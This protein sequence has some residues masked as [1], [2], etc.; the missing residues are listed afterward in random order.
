MN[1]D[2]A[3][4]RTIT[5]ALASVSNGDHPFGAVVL[6]GGAVVAD[7][8]NEVV[9]TVDPTAH[10]EIV[11]IRR[12]CRARGV[13]T[14]PGHT[15]H[16]SCE[17]CAMCRAVIARCGIEQ[18]HHLAARSTAARFGFTDGHGGD[19][20]RPACCADAAVDHELPFTSW[21]TRARTGAPR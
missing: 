10:A 20:Q 9:S 15:L 4:A 8:G 14:L 18:V 12:A 6:D 5:L 16:T 2:E 1:H 21:L 3:A 17:P 7:G 19:A 11:A 13:L